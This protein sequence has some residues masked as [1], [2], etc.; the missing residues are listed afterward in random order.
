MSSSALEVVSTTTGIERS[1]VSPLTSASTSR[2]SL[3]G[4]LRSSRIRSGRRLPSVRRYSIAWTPSPTT[5]SVLWTL[6][7]SNASLMSTTSPGSSSTSRTLIGSASDWVMGRQSEAEGRPRVRRLG[8][9]PHAPV[10]VLDDLAAHGEADARAL[11]ARARVDALEDHEDPAGVLLVDAD[12]V[13][14]AAEAP[15]AVVALGRQ[16]DDGRRV[17]AEL[18]RVA[19]QV[20]EPPPQPPR[21]PA[22]GGQRA[23]LDRRAGLLDR[24][25]EVG[26]HARDQLAAVDVAARQLAPPDAPE[27]DPAVDQ[28]LHPPRP[29]DGEFDVGVGA[30]VELPAVALLQQLAEARDLAQRLLQVV[31]RHVGE[32]LELLVGALEVI[33]L[34]DDPRA[35]RVHVG[36]EHHDPGRAAAGHR[37]VE[38]AGGD[39]AH[40]CREPAQ[41]HH[42]YAAQD[43][44][45]G[46]HAEQDHD[47]G[48]DHPALHDAGAVVE[49]AARVQALRGQRHGEAFER[50]AGWVQALLSLPA[51]VE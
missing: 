50:R 8:V 17:A 30:L 46:E 3:R 19:D 12:P 26:A 31:R 10:V 16:A 15:E 41:R 44:R 48:A 18:D 21:I 32:L 43:Q 42:D 1:A 25:G 27:R 37:L 39:R 35:H 11:V 33:A 5:C 24:R 40:A 14:L 23:G 22:H 38:L 4:R 47:P 45:R 29:V 9:Q 36:A 28:V 7:C 13:V 2:P 20:L 6:L 51:P 49:P 34:L